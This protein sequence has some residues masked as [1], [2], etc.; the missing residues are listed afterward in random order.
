[1]GPEKAIYARTGEET[2]ATIGGNALHVPK[3]ES[4]I[5]HRH[6]HRRALL[7]DTERGKAFGDKVAM[8]GVRAFRRFP[9]RLSL[10]CRR[11]LLGLRF[12]LAPRLGFARPRHDRQPLGWC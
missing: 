1:M 6:Q 9:K 8:R 2:L 11:V 12:G 4:R 10:L 7:P 5:K 3:H